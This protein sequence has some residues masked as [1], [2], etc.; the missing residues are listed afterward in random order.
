MAEALCQSAD[1]SDSVQMQHGT[2]FWSSQIWSLICWK[3]KLITTVDGHFTGELCGARSVA[4]VCCWSLTVVEQIS[5]SSRLWLS[6]HSICEIWI[7]K[8]LCGSET[9]RKWIKA[10]LTIVTTGDWTTR[11]SNTFDGETFRVKVY[12]GT[13]QTTGNS[14]AWDKSVTLS[15]MSSSHWIL[16]E[17]SRPFEE[18]QTKQK[19]D[20]IQRAESNSVRRELRKFAASLTRWKETVCVYLPGFLK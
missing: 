20:K 6:C 18:S 17:T 19:E 13:G 7:W 3:T 9:S 15:S 1:R 10:L 12:M 5:V 8:F 14:H 11:H 16:R 4:G 2:P